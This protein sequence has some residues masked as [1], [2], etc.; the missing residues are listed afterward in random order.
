VT[1]LSAGEMAAQRMTL[2]KRTLLETREQIDWLL[3]GEAHTDVP[4]IVAK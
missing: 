4:A 2:L 1:A 3:A